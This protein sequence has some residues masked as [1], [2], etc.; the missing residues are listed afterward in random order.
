MSSTQIT[1]DKLL[2]HLF[3]INLEHRTDRLNM[4]KQELSKLKPNIG[5]RFN[6]IK[7]ANG[8]VGCTMSHIK[9][10]EKARDKGLPHIFICEDDIKF[11]NPQLLMKNIQ[12]FCE[13]VKDWD[14]LI[15]GGNSVPPYQ[16]IGDFV[17][18]SAIFKQ[19]LDIL[20]DSIIMIH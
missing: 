16:P 4:V 3:F 13:N 20:L 7:V 2:E 10:L 9:C 19:P 18:A 6:A 1:S 14:V 15:I 12:K 8:A 5:T 11:M 17:R